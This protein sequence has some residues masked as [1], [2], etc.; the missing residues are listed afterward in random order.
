MAACASSSA[1]GG[2]GRSGLP[3]PRSITRGP[4]RARSAA[5]AARMPAKYCAGRR[6]ISSG[7]GRCIRASWR[8]GM[9]GAVP[10]GLALTLSLLVLA[11]A[12]A[13]AV[14]R[15]RLLPEWAAAC[16]GAALLVALGAVSAHDAGAALRD[17][18][19]TVGFLAALLVLA[20][21]C[22]REGLFTALGA[23][24]AQG[25]RDDPRRLLVLVFAVASGVTAVLSLDAT[26]V[27]LTPVVFATAARLRTSP[28]PHVYACTHLANSASLL[29]PVSNLTNLLAFHAS[30]LSFTRFGLLMT[31][32]WIAALSVEWAVLSRFFGRTG[33]GSPA[34]ASTP[35]V[36]EIPHWPRFALAVVGLALV[37]FVL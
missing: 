22:R 21:G 2:G 5:T 13:A 6:C 16:G 32:P 1:C 31:L 29:L 28:R 17:L 33:P 11:V 27:L 24:M 23:L 19:P 7:G 36:S 35:E 9:I 37:G 34:E 26:V 18:A 15:P 4:G 8:P 10:D 20:D 25:A 30:G 14:A 3:R 12:L